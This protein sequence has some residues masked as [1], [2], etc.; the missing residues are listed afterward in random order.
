MRRSS[1]DIGADNAAKLLSW[2]ESTPLGKVPRNQFGATSKV[3]VCRLLNIAPSTIGTNDAISKI[4]ENL[5]KRLSRVSVE[6]KNDIHEAVQ[7]GESVVI[8]KLLTEIDELRAEL[9][10]FQHLSDSGQ[11]IWK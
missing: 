11:W 3:P 2:V 1:Q 7:E 6:P 5:D 4:F 9:A 10:R 8:R